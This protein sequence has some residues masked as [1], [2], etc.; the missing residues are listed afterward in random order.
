MKNNL[1]VLILF[2]ILLIISF[3]IALNAYDFSKDSGLNTTAAATGHMEAGVAAQSDQGLAIV[4]GQYIQIALSFVGVLFFIL[5]IYA[6]FIWM[7]ARGNDQQVE[8]AKKILINS[9]AGVI[10]VLA[11]YTITSFVIG[12]SQSTSNPAASEDADFAACEPPNC[13]WID[14]EAV[15]VDIGT[16]G[17]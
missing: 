9:L 4:I 2:F 10:I 14:G 1:L 8:K 13:V 7:T 11:A 12:N 6:G 15:Y 16:G 5:M 3:P 17:R